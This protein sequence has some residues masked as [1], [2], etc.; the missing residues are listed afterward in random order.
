MDGEIH[1]DPF[2][3]VV[4]GGKRRAPVTPAG[5]GGRLDDPLPWPKPASNVVESLTKSMLDENTAEWTGWANGMYTAFAGPCD[6]VVRL[7][8][9]N[10]TQRCGVQL[11]NEDGEVLA[12]SYHA[13]DPPLLPSRP[14]SIPTHTWTEVEGM[15]LDVYHD[16]GHSLEVMIRGDVLHFPS[17]GEGSRWWWRVRERFDYAP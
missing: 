13:L 8:P 16:A 17:D 10:D 6:T 9:L 3:S 1:H 5:G 11:L 15:N 4:S 12:A 14:Q 7:E 2:S